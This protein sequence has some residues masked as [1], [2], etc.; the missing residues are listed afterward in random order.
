MET[1]ASYSAGMRSMVGVLCKYVSRL[2]ARPGELRGK[3]R[4]IVFPQGI[5]MMDATVQFI[6]WAVLFEY[7]TCTGT[8]DYVCG[9]WGIKRMERPRHRAARRPEAVA[10]RK[11]PR[12]TCRSCDRG[13]SRGTHG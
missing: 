7:R 5:F 1:F 2:L 6:L 11:T 4:Y 3:D 10:F 12:P 9:I 8:G 13:G